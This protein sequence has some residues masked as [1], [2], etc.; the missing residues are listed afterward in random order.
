MEL[1]IRGDTWQTIGDNGAEFINLKRGDIIFNHVQARQLLENGKITQGKRRGK[2]IGG[3]YAGGTGLSFNTT[4]TTTEKT[5]KTT[6]T[7][8]SVGGGKNKGKGKGKSKSSS[9]KTSTSKNAGEIF[10]WIALKVET[11]ER[12]IKKLDTTA[13]SVFNG[14]NSR[15]TD[16]DAQIKKVKELIDVQEDA[17]QAYGEIRNGSLVRSETDSDVLATF[18]PFK[19]NYKKTEKN[20]E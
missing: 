5:K 20:H 13:S 1:L 16:I 12:E 15:S 17:V 9:K 3:A 6:T 14:W 19:T 11:L 8:G 10:D 2:L 18:K 7:S 4:T